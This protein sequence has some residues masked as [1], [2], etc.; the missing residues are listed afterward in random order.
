MISHAEQVIHAA[1]PPGQQGIWKTT[2]VI[3]EAWSK[4]DQCKY[5]KSNT[6]PES[7]FK[8]HKPACMSVAMEIFSTK[9][10]LSLS[11]MSEYLIILGKTMKQVLSFVHRRL[12]DVSINL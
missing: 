2:R 10:K 4:L 8:L 5:A 11:G 3:V 7:S 6:Y 12:T 9:M 1:W